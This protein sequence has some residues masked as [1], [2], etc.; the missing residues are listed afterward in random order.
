MAPRICIATDS[1]LGQAPFFLTGEQ[2]DAPHVREVRR[3]AILTRHA[4]LWRATRM[5]DLSKQKGILRHDLPILIAQ[6]NDDKMSVCRVLLAFAQ[7]LCLCF[8]LNTP[9]ITYLDKSTSLLLYI[10]RHGLK[11]YPGSLNGTMKHKG[12]PM[13]RWQR[14]CCPLLSTNQR[15][16]A[17][18]RVL[19][20][21][22]HGGI[23]A[24]IEAPGGHSTPY[25]H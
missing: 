7:A 19:T 17:R 24:G 20:I 2:R 3:D 23:T 21:G 4:S 1:A 22:N 16:G 18:R 25:L 9:S 15:R 11:L 14:C 10:G 5:T 13:R 12:I 6:E 8:C